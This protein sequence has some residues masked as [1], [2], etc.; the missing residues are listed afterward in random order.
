MTGKYIHASAIIDSE[1]EIGINTK[2]WHFSHVLSNS[3]IGQDCV[4][5]QNVMIGPDVYIGNNCKIQNNVSVYKGLHIEDNV[6]CGPSCVFTNVINPRANIERKDE[7]KK[8]FVREG[9]SIGA[10]A[11]IIC[12]VELGKYSIIGAGAVVTKDVK[13]HSVVIGNPAKH[14]AYASEAGCIMSD[15]LYCSYENIYYE[16]RNGELCKK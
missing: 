15:E 16:I 14:Y 5:G 8:T 6:F 12:G 2:I 7:F 10:N 3:V 9:C 1:V 4:I 11:T 13:P